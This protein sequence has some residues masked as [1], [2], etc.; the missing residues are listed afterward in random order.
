MVEIAVE[1]SKVTVPLLWLKVP[2]AVCVKLSVIVKVA[3]VALNIPEE[4]VRFLVVMLE[5]PLVKVPPDW[6]KVPPTVRLYPFKLK[7]PP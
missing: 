4:M 2:P 5:A 3:V 6:L 1:D 7:V